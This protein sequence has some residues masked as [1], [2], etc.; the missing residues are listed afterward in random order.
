[1]PAAKARE[2]WSNPLRSTLRITP[3][4]KLTAAF[5][6]DAQRA[7]DPQGTDPASAD[8]RAEFTVQGGTTVQ[9]VILRRTQ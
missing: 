1:M 2:R 5:R 6:T 9:D 3:Q 8:A 4:Q 7:A